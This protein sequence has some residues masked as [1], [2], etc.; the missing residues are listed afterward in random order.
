MHTSRRNWLQAGAVL[1]ATDAAAKRGRP[2]A[3]AGL[4]ACVFAT[5]ARGGRGP[6]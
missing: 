4:P 5:R 6:S 1:A 3:S 2:E